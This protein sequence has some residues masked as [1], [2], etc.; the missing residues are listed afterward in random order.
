MGWHGP[1]RFVRRGKM[2]S[3]KLKQTASR[4][5]SSL[6]RKEVISLPFDDMTSEHGFVSELLGSQRKNEA[7]YHLSNLKALNSHVQQVL[8]KKEEIHLLK[9]G[10]STQSGLV[11]KDRSE[12]RFFVIPLHSP[13]QELLIFRSDGKMYQSN[14]LLFGLSSALWIFTKATKPVVTVLKTLGNRMIIHIGDLLVVAPGKDMAQEHTKCLMFLSENL[15]FTVN[16]Q[17]F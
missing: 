8:F 5:A 16:R 13:D 2:Y 9:P 1:H 4:Q 11:D 14:C 12:R 3:P 10:H 17:K 7:S 6:L 15:G